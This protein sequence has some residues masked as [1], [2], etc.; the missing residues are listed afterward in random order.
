M[1][2]YTCI[3]YLV[4]TDRCW[5]SKLRHTVF[6]IRYA[7]RLKKKRSEIDVFEVRTET[8]GTLSIEHDRR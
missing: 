5:F 1:L 8:Q 7:L 6:S 3:A 2:R 4:I